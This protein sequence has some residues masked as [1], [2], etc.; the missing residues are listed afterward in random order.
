MWLWLRLGW[1]IEMPSLLSG[2][3]VLAIERILIVL[4]GALFA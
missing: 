2:E 4:I 1:L 3:G